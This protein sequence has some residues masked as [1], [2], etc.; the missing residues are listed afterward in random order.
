MAGYQMASSSN[1]R[2][3]IWP[4]PKVVER[5]VT[6]KSQT[7][8]QGPVSISDKTSYRKILWS[9]EAARLVVQ[10]IASFWNLT[11]TSTAL[12]P[13]CLSNFRAIGQF[14]IQISRLRD[15]TRSYSKTSYRILKRGPGW[16]P[17]QYK[18]VLSGMRI[19]IA[20]IALSRDNLI[21]TMGSSSW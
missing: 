7:N 6:R 12:L 15:F 4:L 13:R 5:C 2:Q 10:I 20:K 11:G 3:V 19:L 21:F 9:L 16:V 18:T 14:W 8:T 1:G 17:F